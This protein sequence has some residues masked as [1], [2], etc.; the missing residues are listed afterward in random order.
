MLTGLLFARIRKKIIEEQRY[1]ALGGV[2]AK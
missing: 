2:D 1:L